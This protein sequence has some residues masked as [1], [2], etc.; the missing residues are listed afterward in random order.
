MQ[1]LLFVSRFMLHGTLTFISKKAGNM[2]YIIDDR[3]KVMRSFSVTY[4]RNK[5]FFS[6]VLKY[7]TP[8]GTTLSLLLLIM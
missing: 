6:I 4:M 8:L 1:L 2:D 3:D 7:G 5:C